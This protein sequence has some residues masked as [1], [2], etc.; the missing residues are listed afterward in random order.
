M[1]ENGV[2]GVLVRFRGIV[3]PLPKGIIYLKK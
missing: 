1:G 3:A 2:A